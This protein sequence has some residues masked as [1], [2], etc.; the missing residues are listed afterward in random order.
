MNQTP[1]Y[2]TSS[3]SQ[4]SWDEF[5]SQQDLEEFMLLFR[6][7]AVLSNFTVEQVHGGGK[8]QSKP[9]VEVRVM[10]IPWGCC[11]C[12]YD[13]M[14]ANLDVQY[15]ESISFPTPNTCY[16]TGG[17]PPF[18]PDLNTQTDTNEPYL[19]W[20]DVILDQ[21]TIPQTISTSYGDDEQT[22]PP[23]YA[24]SVCDLFAQLGTMGVSVLFSSGDN[25]VGSGSC[26]TND[27][28]DRVQF[29]PVFPASCQWCSC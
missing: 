25:G 13:I 1:R 17:F 29:I 22:V 28:T 26:L 20:L 4:V 10:H 19:D 2:K 3:G 14:Q 8:D 27:G 24:D 9:G 15:A 7:D 12:K 5:A 6:A 16:S 23:D 18:T 11:D 21:E